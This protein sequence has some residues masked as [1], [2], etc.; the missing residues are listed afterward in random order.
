VK[1]L[2]VKQMNGYVLFA[3]AGE[4]TLG[5]LVRVARTVAQE[6]S[7]RECL[8]ALIDVRESIGGLSMVDK[9]ELAEIAESLK[10]RGIRIA[11]LD[12]PQDRADGFLE[13]V[14][15]NRAIAL[16]LFF[17]QDRAV[18]WLLEQAPRKND[19]RA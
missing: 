15:S 13:T 4:H 16:R 18:E 11:L 7:T 3:F 6:C 5:R 2:R 8:R 12:R 14:A 17:N 19:A 1:D 10:P 9:F